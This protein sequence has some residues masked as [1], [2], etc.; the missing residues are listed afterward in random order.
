MTIRIP[1][2]VLWALGVLL[3]AGA[4]A[5][6]FLVGRSSDDDPETARSSSSATSPTSTI[7]TTPDPTAVPAKCS[8]REAMRATEETEFADE[9]LAVGEA[10]SQI[11]GFGGVSGP[12]VDGPFFDETTG[13]RP[14]ILEC[15][16]LTGDE[17][18]EMIFAPSAG[19]SG[20]I[21]NW[22]IF[23]PDENGEWRL[24]FDR[25]AV[26]IRDIK[27]R[28]D[29]VVETAPT[30]AEGEPLCCPSGKRSTE[31]AF[32]DGDFKVVSP[33]ATRNERLIEVSSS[34]VDGLGDF[35]P[36]TDSSAE[37]YSAFGIPSSVTHID[38]ACDYAWED[39][40]LTIHFANFG[41]AD[42][43]GPDGA[44]GSFDILGSAAQHAGWHTREGAEI[45]MSESELTDLYPSAKTKRGEL[46]LVEKSSPIG[47]GN[48]L[49]VLSAVMVDGDAKAF[50]VYVGA[51]GE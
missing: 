15:R 3:V 33:V 40:G 46:V 17:V 49:P 42:P 35:E 50:R 26:K 39:L 21:F 14:A 37:T 51:A 6:A 31:F 28:G 13:Y 19:A 43:C 11:A 2:W 4:I 10:Q 41:G 45:G 20:S 25:E 34:G 38:E 36:E 9:I 12:G 32:E 5:A 23:T 7:S 16:D 24:A 29:I 47:G 1:K 44:V 30:Y 48:Y 27:I 18:E 8:E 22:A